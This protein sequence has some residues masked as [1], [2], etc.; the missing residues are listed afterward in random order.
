MTFFVCRPRSRSEYAA[1]PG[2]TAAGFGGSV[3]MDGNGWEDPVCAQD[4][5]YADG[6]MPPLRR[7]TFGA[8]GFLAT[9]GIPLVAGRDFTWDEAYQKLPVA[10]VSENFAREYWGSPA[11]AMGKH[12]RVGTKDDWRE[13]VG[14]IGDVHDEA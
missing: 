13:I 8:P 7:F 2:V 4:R 11:N 6:S 10:M 5:S 12:I 9:L 1:L 3:P 14:V